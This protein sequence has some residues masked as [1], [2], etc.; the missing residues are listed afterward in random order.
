MAALCRSLSRIQRW[1]LRISARLKAVRA[2]RSACTADRGC[3]CV[4]LLPCL[5]TWAALLLFPA[6]TWLPKDTAPAMSVLCCRWSC[7]R[8]LPVPT[9]VAGDV[10]CLQLTYRQQPMLPPATAYSC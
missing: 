6:F 2:A 5:H 1:G 7:Q 9:I 4:P 3:L 10:H 8:C